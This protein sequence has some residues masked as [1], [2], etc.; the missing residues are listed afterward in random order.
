[1]NEEQIQAEIDSINWGTALDVITKGFGVLKAVMKE[2]NHGRVNLVLTFNK[3]TFEQ[4]CDV[5]L[6]MYGD[7]GFMSDDEGI[8]SDQQMFTAILHSALSSLGAHLLNES[9]KKSIIDEVEGNDC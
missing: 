2:D 5:A 9:A 1:M 7:L 6:Q 8:P 3:D 4:A